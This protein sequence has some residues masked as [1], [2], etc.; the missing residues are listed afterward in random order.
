MEEKKQLT[1][2]RS[3]AIVAIVVAICL[4]VALVASGQRMGSA[5]P[6][7]AQ[8]ETA[9]SGQEAS[10]SDDTGAAEGGQENA[11]KTAV[12]GAEALSLWTDASETKQKLVPYMEAITDESSADFIPVERRV[13]VFDLDGTLVSETNPIYFDH[14]LLLYRVLQDPD[15]MDKASDFEKETCYKILEGIRAGEYPKGM[16]MMHGQAVASAFAGMTVDDFVDYVLNFREEAAPG[17]DGMTRKDSFY[18]PMLEIVEYLQ[19]N[20]FTV[21]VV[22]GT[23]RLILRG[24]VPEKMNIPMSQ[25]IGSDE[26]IVSSSQG[27]EDGLEY[28]LTAGDS[29]ILGGEFVTKNLKMN[30][31]SVIAQEIGVQPVLSFGNSTGDSSMA[32]YVISNNP[33]KSLAFM[34]CCDDLE[35]EYGNESKAQKMKDLCAEH[36]WIPVSMR[37]DWTTIYG[38]GVTKNPDAGLSWYYDYEIPEYS[39]AIPQYEYPGPEAFYTVLYDYLIA[40]TADHYEKADVSIPCPHIL[41]MDESDKSDIK[42]YGDFWIY[43]YKLNG[44]TLECESGGS[45]PGV[46]HLKSVDAAPGYEVT[47]MEVCEDGNDFDPSAKKIFGDKYDA[48]MKMYS[49]SEAKE[50]TRAQIIAN[51]VAANNLDITEYKDF[52][53]DPVKL[54][55]ENIDTFYSD[56]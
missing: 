12:S 55:E 25:V 41:D 11:D 24:I 46:I 33:Y 8:I 17:Y 43:N 47:S 56:L 54:P 10:Q 4:G 35:R 1:I 34:L 26:T 37:D 21:Y 18:S 53:W 31:V 14:S 51:Y 13:A 6:E 50:V 15:Y 38:D 30:K 39:S 23:D 3:T 44:Q 48:F 7:T 40:E 36:G 2:W 49:D 20:D 5:G 27:A 28:Q 42:V 52:G 32:D 16:D 45:Y 19:A 29:L 9:D 22:S